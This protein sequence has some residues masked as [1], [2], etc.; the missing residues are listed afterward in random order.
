MSI[1]SSIKYSIKFFIFF[2]IVLGILYP[3]TIYIAGQ[4]FFKNKADGSLYVKNGVVR[5]SYL[6]GQKFTSD[7]YFWPRPSAID[8]NPYPSGASNLSQTSDTLLKQYKQRKNNFIKDNM[9]PEKTHVPSDM[10]FAS[11]SGVDPDISK[12]SAILQTKRIIITRKFNKLQSDQLLNLINS[13]TK[14][15]QFGILGHEV[16]NVLKLNLKLDEMSK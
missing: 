7:K 5:G 9:L 11:A 15:S 14:P 1:L 8:Y 3:L 16:I 4:V 12:E 10:L 2:T 6:L 13:L